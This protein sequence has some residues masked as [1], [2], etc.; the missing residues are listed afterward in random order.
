MSF[1]D[2]SFHGLNEEC[3]VIGVINVPNANYYLYLGLHALQHRGQEASGMVTIDNNMVNIV[4]RKGSIVNSFSKEDMESLKGN[5]GLGHVR[6]ST[7]GGKST[8]NIQPFVF[9]LHHTQYVTCHNGNIVNASTL[10]KKLEKRGSIFFSFSDSEL[11][12]HLI[13]TSKKLTTI[14]KIDESLKELV[15]AF[16]FIV[17]ENNK[18]YGCRDKWGLRPLV[19]GKLKDGYILASETVAL[20]AVGANFIRDVEPGE[21]IEISN[22]G[23]ISSKY[24]TPPKQ[25]KNNMC[26]MEYI[27]FARPDTILEGKNVHEKRVQTGRELAKEHPLN[28]DIVIGVPDSSLSA[29]LGYSQYSKIPYDIGLVKNK[30]IGRSFIAPS[31]EE[32]ER[33]VMMKLNPNKHVLENKRVILVDDSIV[34]GT[35]MKSIVKLI[36]DAGAKEIHIRIASPEIKWPCFYGVDTSR[37]AE[38]ALYAQ[39]KDEYLRNLKYA[40]SLEFISLNGLQKS[41]DR[42]TKNGNLCTA[43]FSGKY[44][45]KLHDCE[46]EVNNENK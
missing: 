32:R 4:K 8:I 6:Y 45:S 3:G 27:Y 16:S 30:Y 11:L 33:I 36:H 37:R 43:C 12:G 42:W 20:D 41:L 28:A 35:T 7:F 38:L 1:K 46:N 40:T 26:A 19:L 25:C 23:N 44:P 29:A 14:D 13:N 18:I 5:I 22:D 39:S 34:R 24:Y 2:S 9:T 15:G 17:I 21:I 31:Q 10:K